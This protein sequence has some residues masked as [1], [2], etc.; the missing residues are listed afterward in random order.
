MSLLR[1]TSSGNWKD[2]ALAQDTEGKPR[3]LAP[4]RQE[5]RGALRDCERIGHELSEGIQ[6]PY[7]SVSVFLSPACQRFLCFSESASHLQAGGPLRDA[8]DGGW[9]CTRGMPL[10]ITTET[11][12]KAHSHTGLP[13]P[14][15]AHQRP[16]SQPPL[17][18]PCRPGQPEPVWVRSVALGLLGL[19][20]LVVLSPTWAAP[21]NPTAQNTDQR[22]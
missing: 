3:L 12:K 21:C 13:A 8:S 5:A 10:E 11:R 1:A 19:V 22:R 2:G 16:S 20:G 14:V 9:C 15:P 18:R 7:R 17:A 4:W 6:A